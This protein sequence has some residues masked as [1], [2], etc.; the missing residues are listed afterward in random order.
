MERACMQSNAAC[1]RLI[2]RLFTRGSRSAVHTCVQRRTVA[3][4]LGDRREAHMQCS[5]SLS[6]PRV[7]LV[8]MVDILL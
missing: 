2:A 5:F 1:M 6:R 7:S 3:L 8:P 4:V